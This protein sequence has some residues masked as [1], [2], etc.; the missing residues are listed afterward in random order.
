[1]TEEMIAQIQYLGTKRGLK[2]LYHQALPRSTGDKMKPQVLALGFI[3]IECRVCRSK[4]G[5]TTQETNYMR[6]SRELHM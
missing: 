4:E 5:K 3:I 2:E 1:M 6:G